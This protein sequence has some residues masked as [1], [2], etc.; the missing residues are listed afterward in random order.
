LISGVVS[1]MARAV[2]AMKVVFYRIL[3]RH[4]LDKQGPAGEIALFDALVKVSLVAFP[5]L[6]N[7]RLGLFI[8]QAHDSLL[9]TKMK[10]DP[11][12]FILSVDE[13]EGVAAESA[14]VP[15]RRSSGFPLT[16]F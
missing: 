2:L 10:L 11:I 5:V 3:L 9:S 14:H 1:A 16:I 13:A 8:G 4:D 12:S 7:Y 15:I 6:A